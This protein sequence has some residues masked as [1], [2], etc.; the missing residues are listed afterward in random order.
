MTSPFASSANSQ[1]ILL[2]RN[3]KCILRCQNTTSVRILVKV[4]DTPTTSNADYFLEG[5]DA[6]EIKTAED[7]SV[8]II[9]DAGTPNVYFRIEKLTLWN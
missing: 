7:T 8:N 9:A 2:P 5:G 4:G 6:V 1:A 3:H